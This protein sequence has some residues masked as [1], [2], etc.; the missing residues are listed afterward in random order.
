M[1]SGM[2]KLVM[3]SLC[4]V[5]IGLSVAAQVPQVALRFEVASI[6]L[7]KSG[8]ERVSGGF[9][10]GGNY[11]VTNYPLRSLIA[12]AYLRPQIN[13][14]F[15]IAGGPEWI[16]SDRF[17]IEAKAATE[18]PTGPD[19]PTAPRRVM[20]QTLLAERFGLKVHHETRQGDVYAITFARPDKQIGPNFKRSGL[21]CI[22]TPG[23]ASNPCAV[24]VGPGTISSAGMTFAQLIGLL[25]RFVDRV[26]I[27]TTG[28]TDRFEIKI[29][30]TPAPG[31]WIAPPLADIAAPI[32][33]GP[34]L[35]TAMQ[36]QLGLKLQP[37]KGP[38]DWLVVDH[39]E[40]PAQN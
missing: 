26:V 31:E 33:D 39:A 21:D 23:A 29:T 15:L 5:V 35:F 30:W 8:E 28:L 34:S 36:E 20:L 24:K 18:F 13:P 27:D 2:G 10:P 11:R 22:A 7:N 38:I 12:A 16:D 4:T 25:P 40:R 9:M 17:D 14:D 3:S 19:G 6:K 1:L 32:A 37:Q